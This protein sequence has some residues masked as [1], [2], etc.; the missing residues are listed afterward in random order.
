MIQAII[1]GEPVEY[2]LREDK[3]SKEPT[4]WKLKRLTMA[5]E[6]YI[7]GLAMKA[8]DAE[9][10]SEALIEQQKK[11]LSI[12]LLSAKPFKNRK[13]EDAIFER[14]RKAGAFWKDVLFWTDETLEQIE[15]RHRDELA[16]AIISGGK[17]TEEDRK[18]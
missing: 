13:G 7:T 2:I 17:L 14:D 16:A 8:R 10:E 15:R 11:L 3:A 18:N 12:G 9:D 5:E 6:A 1:P 4:V